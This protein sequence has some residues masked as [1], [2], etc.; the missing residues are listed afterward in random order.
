M[1]I[2]GIS[3]IKG[4]G[5]YENYTKPAGTPD[6]GV[7]NLI[8]GWNYSGK[9]T[10]SRL[11]ALLEA[12][13]PNADLAGCAFTF[14]ADGQVINETNFTQSTLSVRV[15]NSDFIRDNL[16]FSGG[17]FRPILILGK[18]SEA[19]QERILKFD[20]RVK[21]AQHRARVVND[22]LSDVAAA[23]ANAKTERAKAIR[24]TLK[25]DPY[26]ATHLTN[27]MIAVEVLES[28]LLSE[29]DLKENLELAQT[30]D[31]MRPSTVEVVS[32]F[33]AI[34]LLHADAVSALATTPS[35]SS[36]IKHLEENP[37]VERWVESG[38]TIHSGKSHC[39]FC[40]NS[41]IEERM[42]SLRAHFSKDLSDHKAKLAKLLVR[43]QN[44]DFSIHLPKETEFNVR[45][46]QAFNE[47][48]SKIPE[49]LKAYNLAIAILRRDIQSKV[50]A[51]LKSIFPTAIDGG[52]DQAIVDAVNAVNKVVE[53]NNQLAANFVSAKRAAIQKV[54]NHLVQEFIDS[55]KLTRR[56][57]LTQ[58][59]KA[60]QVRVS[61][62]IEVCQTEINELQ[63]Q[64]SKAQLGRKSINERLA[65]MLG[66]EA[67]QI[68]VVKD[69]AGQ[70]RFQLVRKNGKP[71][72]NLSDGERTAIAFSYFLAKL[73]ELTEAEFEQTIVYIDD[74]ISS[75]DAN[76]LFQVTAAIKEMFFCQ[77]SVNNDKVWTT[78]CK[79]FFLST[80]NFQFFDLVRDLDPKKVG[81]AQLYF[82]RKVNPTN[83][84]LGQMPPS[85]SKYSS[86]YHFLFETVLKFRAA[87]DKATYEGLMLLPNAVRR[88]TELYTYSRIPT[89]AE[90]A[91]TTV[92]RRAEKLFG[93]EATK[94][95]LKV[96]HYFSHANNIER[97]AVNNDLI[98]DLEHA[99]NDL[100]TLIEQRDPLHWA[101]LMEA[102]T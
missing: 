46:R 100:L 63:A 7:K 42:G 33:P 30:P 79:Q 70:E 8:Y 94:R 75:L 53:E 49:L 85:L 58:R 48:A 44:A 76:H 13:A 3:R 61:S 59:L 62:F 37:D 73:Q 54:K 15:F 77:K 2:T 55:H 5:V 90:G 24:T 98:F 78:R 26:I 56:D 93:S 83:S 45:Y 40:G 87:Q 17:N 36:T 18:E 34:G 65:S 10:L 67:V 6:F 43:V 88:F 4:L 51:P 50:D 39:E 66:S 102:V 35:F 68:A 64:I 89:K 86:E 60:W 101:A 47:A 11:F 1:L 72:I 23:I 20:S 32:A 82:L 80:H 25:I 92:D 16:H 31:S 27:D 91:D 14:E 69:G 22:R 95:I 97:F 38:L 84:I 99:V 96:L 71:A 57:Q 9:T 29:K 12:K 81:R 41:L 28:T 19:A 74:P 21:R 52:I